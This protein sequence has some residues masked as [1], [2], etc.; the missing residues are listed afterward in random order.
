MK[1]R[2]YFRLCAVVI[3][4]GVVFAATEVKALPHDV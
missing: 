4:T 3:A 2:N 1:T